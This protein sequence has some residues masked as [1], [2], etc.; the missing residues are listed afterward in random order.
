MEGQYP[1]SID[2]QRAPKTPVEC[3]SCHR[4]T[5][6][7]EPIMTFYLQGD[8]KMRWTRTYCGLC[9]AKWTEQTKTALDRATAEVEKMAR[10]LG[11]DFYVTKEM[12]GKE[13]RKSLK[14]IAES[15]P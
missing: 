14:K 10:A 9:A 1:L 6:H 4:K 12:F 3:R 13:A 7:G 11:D 5:I 8:F 2:A 15:Q